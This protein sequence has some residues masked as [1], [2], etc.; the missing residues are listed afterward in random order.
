MKFK[1][2]RKAIND[3]FLVFQV[4]YC[5]VQTLLR[6]QNPFAYNSGIYG[7]NCDYYEVNG[8]VI[9]TGYRP[10]GISTD[11]TREIFNK[12]EKMAQALDEDN[13]L[14]YEKRRGYINTLVDMCTDELKKG[15][16]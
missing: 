15:D 12:Y 14:D 1:T 4:S 7:W 5:G 11:K 9:C 13:S 16:S 2:T 3:R 6:Y 8:I 10:H